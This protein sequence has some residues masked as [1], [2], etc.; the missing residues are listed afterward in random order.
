MNISSYSDRFVAIVTP[1]DGTGEKEVLFPYS[2][3]LDDVLAW[4]LA[5]QA[6]GLYSNIKIYD[7]HQGVQD[8]T[9]IEGD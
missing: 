9:V 7:S 3:D 8:I 2:Y 6:A 1:Y 4:V 5:T